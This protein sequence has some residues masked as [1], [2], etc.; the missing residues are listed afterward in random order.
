MNRIGS[1][2]RK[3]DRGVVMS[4]ALREEQLNYEREQSEQK[5]SRIK[6]GAIRWLKIIAVYVGALALV[7]LLE[8]VLNLSSEATY[9]LTKMVLYLTTGL[10]VLCKALGIFLWKK[11]APDPQQTQK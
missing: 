3:H 5:R 2:A 10:L 4:E 11:K 6:S 9:H 1:S 7:N 8:W